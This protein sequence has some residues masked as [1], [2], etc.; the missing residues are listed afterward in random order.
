MQTKGMLFDFNTGSYTLSGEG[1]IC[2]DGYLTKK[3]KG[4][5]N[6]GLEEN[7]FTGPV[8]L[9]E[10]KV[11]VKSIANGGVASSLGA[12]SADEGNLKLG[13]VKLTVLDDNC[14]TDRIL[15]LTGDSTEIDVK[16]SMSIT[17]NIVGPNSVFVKSGP[18]QLNLVYP[19]EY[20]YKETVVKEGILSQGN[21]LTYFGAKNSK[22]TLAGGTVKLIENN[23]MNTI[24]SYTYP[25]EVKE[26]TENVIVGTFRSNILGT[27]TG[28]GT[29]TIYGG[30]DRCAIHSDFSKFEG[31]LKLQ[32]ANSMWRETVTDMPLTDVV[33]DG[34]LSLYRINNR[35]AAQSNK[36]GTLGSLASTYSDAQL[37]AGIWTIGANNHDAVFN[38]KLVSG[39]TVTKVGSGTWTL[40]SGK[41][42]SSIAVNAGRVILFSGTSGSVSVAK[43]AVLAFG[44]GTTRCSAPKVGTDL[45]V[46]GGKVAFNVDVY[47]NDQF[48]SVKNVVL[49]NAVISVNTINGK[50]L[51]V[52]DEITLFKNFESITG[53]FTVQSND[54]EFDTSD[55]LT[56]G[57][58]RVK[59]IST[60]IDGIRMD[61]N[62]IETQYDLQGRAYD[63]DT[64]LRG[65]TIVKQQNGKQKKVRKLI[66]K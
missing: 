44:D 8:D 3:G 58:I 11:T 24:P 21:Y 46:N 17:S 20:G 5:L 22:M 52:G 41:N 57:K 30:G 15:T 27:F 49:D 12:A 56:S 19:G 35:Y 50:T 9:Q 53:T 43:D 38:G 39:S 10:G 55:F 33:I 59:A 26:N 29:V 28:K 42:T 51:T 14:A 6:I 63:K 36:G 60:G 37:G 7:S 54:Y 34:K 40:N 64:Q 47:R 4:D 61:G 23:N 45:V 25:T 18:G 2:G 31:I 48:T 62:S 13:N 66:N 65:V 1:N 16:S 32:G